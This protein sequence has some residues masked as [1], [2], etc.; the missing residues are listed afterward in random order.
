MHIGE[1]D[2]SFGIGR[3]KKKSRKSTENGNIPVV[4]L[5]FP[6]FLPGQLGAATSCLL[7]LVLSVEVTAAAAAD[8]GE[9]CAGIATAA[10]SSHALHAAPF[11]IPCHAGLT[12]GA[13]PFAAHLA[14]V[15]AHAHAGAVEPLDG[16]AFIIA[17]YH[18]AMRGLP[19]ETVELAVL[20]HGVSL[21]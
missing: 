5:W 21:L 14:A 11:A 9:K 16:A 1:S 17:G 18:E 12:L 8:R 10:P 4:S 2:F 3:D 20:V 19:T 7:D 6:I 13:V 15:P